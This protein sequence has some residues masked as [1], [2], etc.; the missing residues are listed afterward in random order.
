MKKI[1]F[2]TKSMGSGGT[3]VSLLNLL[4]KIHNEY[5]ITLAVLK[6][7]GIYINDIP[8]NVK[9]IEIYNDELKRIDNEF[10]F[11]KKHFLSSLNLVILKILKRLNIRFIY[12]YQ[13]RKLKKMDFTYDIAVDF[14]GYGYF[15]TPFI[16]KK[17]NAKRKFMFVHDEKIDWI[18]KVKKELP[19]FD[20][21]LCV[22]NS[23]KKQLEKEYGNLIKEAKMCRNIID[24]EKIKKMSQEKSNVKFETVTNLLTIGRLEYQK[25][26][27]ILIE[28]AKKLK[29][30]NVKF[31]WYIIGQ[32]SLESEINKCLDENDLKEE[33]VLLGM[34]KNPYP[35]IDMC[36]IYVQPSRH[37]GYGIAIAEARILNKPI[38]ATKLECIEEQI[39]NNQNGLLCNLDSE[40]FYQKIQ[41]LIND[42]DKKNELI[43]NLK[44]QSNI[45]NNDFKNIVE[46]I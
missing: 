36:D 44:K 20:E 12:A 26:Y 17:V 40:E 38:I 1:L 25:G 10:L 46:E 42:D 5:D 43:Q 22:S 24:I 15:G 28:I 13:L 14:H 23:C 11:D 39:I 18:K 30:N 37:E 4:K 2:I 27:D 31:N 21:I 9:I 8:E 29:N 19:K 32:G 35:F 6:K 33:V 3:E 41:L 16:I 45:D 7:E 34:Q